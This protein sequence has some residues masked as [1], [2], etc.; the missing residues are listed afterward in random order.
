MRRKHL[1]IG[2]RAGPPSEHIALRIDLDILESHPAKLLG[3]ELGPL[4]FVESGGGDF[5]DLHLFF[6]VGGVV[7]FEVTERLRHRVGQH[8]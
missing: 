1:R 4:T 6:D 8:Q 5:G 2:R 3:Q 7:G